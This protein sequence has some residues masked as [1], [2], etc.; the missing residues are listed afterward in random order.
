MKSAT[1]ERQFTVT[2]TMTPLAFNVDFSQ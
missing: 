2:A 1:A